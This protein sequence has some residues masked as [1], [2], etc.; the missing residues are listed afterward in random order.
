MDY[1][2]AHT[3][4]KYVGSRN[5]ESGCKEYIVTVRLVGYGDTSTRGIHRDYVSSWL[6][7]G[8]PSAHGMCRSIDCDSVNTYMNMI[9]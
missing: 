4:V 1:D 9:M 2:S 5:G 7:G 8:N 3:Y 6:D